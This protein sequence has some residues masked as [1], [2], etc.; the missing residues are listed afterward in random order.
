MIHFYDDQHLEKQHTVAR[1]RAAR[2]FLIARLRRI[3]RV[4]VATP[5]GTMYAFSRVRGVEDSL[6]FCKRLVAE[7]GLDLA[8]GS[9]F[10]P[11]GEGCVRWCIAASEVRLAQG[12]DRLERFLAAN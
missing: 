7:A 11:E 5:L 3:E 12:V 4:E 9:V 10:G 1:C 8:P 6:A 2:D